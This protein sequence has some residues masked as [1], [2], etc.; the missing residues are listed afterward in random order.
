MVFAWLEPVALPGGPL[1]SRAD[2]GLDSVFTVGVK[3]L[4]PAIALLAVDVG[5]AG[6]GLGPFLRC[7]W[8]KLG[9]QFED[10]ECLGV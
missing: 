7:R 1:V 9:T 4:G 10:S 6:I 8:R 2:S 5:C 3:A